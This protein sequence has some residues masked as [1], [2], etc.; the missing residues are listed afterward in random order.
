MGVVVME[1]LAGGV[2]KAESGHGVFVFRRAASDDART[3][4]WRAIS[5]T[6]TFKPPNSPPVAPAE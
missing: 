1:W 2:A 4:P 6:T 5:R 3:P